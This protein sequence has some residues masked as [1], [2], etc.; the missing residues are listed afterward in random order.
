MGWGVFSSICTSVCFCFLFLGAVGSRF[1]ATVK[2]DIFI[3]CRDGLS[4]AA[5][6]SF[7]KL[8]CLQFCG[9]VAGFLGVVVGWVG[10]GWASVP[11]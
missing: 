9:V 1:S 10:L 5:C 4:I 11:V 3:F 2:S 7:V 6:V 8:Y